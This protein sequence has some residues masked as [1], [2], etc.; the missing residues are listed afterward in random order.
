MLFSSFSILES[1]T[2]IIPS[3]PRSKTS[4]NVTRFLCVGKVNRWSLISCPPA[5]PIFTGR[6][7]NILPLGFGASSSKDPDS[8]SGLVFE[9]IERKFSVLPLADAPQ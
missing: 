9:K 8:T 6:N 4:L 5:F 7:S 2:K 3:I 1:E